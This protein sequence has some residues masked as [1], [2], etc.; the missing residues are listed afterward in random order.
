MPPT[1][2]T[3]LANKKENSRN[4]FSENKGQGSDGNPETGLNQGPRDNN[5][6]P[7]AKPGHEP[8]PGQL[9]KGPKKLR[10]GRKQPDLKGTGAK[11]NSKRT[12]I[13]LAC[14]HHYGMK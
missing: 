12:E 8:G 14:A 10:Q 1:K 13:G 2:N 9:H 11:E 6:P 5:D 7:A 4:S 3:N